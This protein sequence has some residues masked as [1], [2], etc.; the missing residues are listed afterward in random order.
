M[1]PVTGFFHLNTVLFV[2][3]GFVKSI[4]SKVISV[5]VPICSWVVCTFRW[6]LKKSPSNKDKEAIHHHVELVRGQ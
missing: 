2:V 1:L 3:Q 4:T 6:D 5:T